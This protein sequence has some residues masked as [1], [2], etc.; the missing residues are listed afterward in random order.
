V[1]D[2]AGD[3]AAAPHLVVCG[4]N[5]LAYRV[6]AELVEH[7]GAEAT[8]IVRSRGCNH[9]PRIAALPNVTL[10]EPPELTADV[11]RRAGVDRADALALVDQDDVGNIR[12]ALRVQ[13]L[14]PD[15]RLVIR[16]S[17]LSLGY[18]IRPMFPGCVVLSRSATAAPSIVAATL[19]EVAP[20]YARLPG[21]PGRTVY[22]TRRADVPARRVVCGLA[23]TTA[24]DGLR[25]LPLDD[26]QADLV[27]AVAKDNRETQDEL[28]VSRSGSHALR[29]LW[30][31]ARVRVLLTRKLVIVTA[32]LL[33]LFGIGTVLFAALSGYSW[34]DAIYLTVLDAAGAAQP[35][36]KF[37]V[38]DKILQVMITLVGISLIPLATAAVV[39][40]IVGARLATAL[41]QPRPV[42]DHVVV[43][44]LGNVGSRVAAQLHDL[45]I[46]VVGVESDERARGVPLARRLGVPVVIGDATRE[47]TLR[48]A[49]VG[50]SRALVAVTDSDVTNLEVGL[51]GRTI[52][53]DLRVVLRMFD[54]DLAEQVQRHC[55]I[56]ISRSVSFLAAPAFAAAMMQRQVLA[57]I[58]VGRTVL[59]LAEVPVRAG[60]ELVGLAASA[61]NLPRQ[62]RLIA[63]QRH[64]SDELDL[65]PRVE[66]LLA[67]GDRLFVVATPA[68]LAT[69]IA[70]SIPAPQ[71]SS[72]PDGETRRLTDR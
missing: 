70:R 25:R 3:V 6:V 44:G 1:A 34:A 65:P 20:S 28:A 56:T 67:G 27:L 59:L 55:G 5:Q 14:N 58:P 8:V 30:A 11:L 57:T 41:G 54:D 66:H 10:I 40:A 64:T 62:A 37:S 12:A 19:G 49:Y 15:L 68:G 35:D 38:A 16:F 4:D 36:A 17:N 13:E 39:D 63:L 2:R 72:S 24:P 26:N 71:P 32:G 18:R 33:T 46:A 69:T 47:D 52:R 31:R 51:Y 21:R 48:E 60:C 45:G 23:D 53:S 7:F 50:T 61:I 9:V 22:M 43:V 42:R 29:R